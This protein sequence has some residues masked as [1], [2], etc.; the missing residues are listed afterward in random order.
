MELKFLIMKILFCLSLFSFIEISTLYGSCWPCGKKFKQAKSKI[1]K[2]S[3]QASESKLGITNE[4]FT[5]PA[6]LITTLRKQLTILLTKNPNHFVLF[7]ASCKDKNRKLSM[8][9]KV[10]LEEAGV[11]SALITSNSDGRL[12]KLI[13][14][15]LMMT[16]A[17]KELIL[18][19]VREIRKNNKITYEILTEEELTKKG[20]S[21]NQMLMI[22]A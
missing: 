11:F 6:A 22:S 16:Q 7:I 8:S 18:M 14:E 5:I 10:T 17:G 19:F 9:M 13:G 20:L 4:E 21:N 12:V 15:T 3:A 1:S 2:S